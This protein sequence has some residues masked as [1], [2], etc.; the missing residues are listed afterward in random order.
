[1]KIIMRRNSMIFYPENHRVDNAVSI[2]QKEAKKW[3]MK[4]KA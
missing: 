3:S 1:M 2:N 4:E